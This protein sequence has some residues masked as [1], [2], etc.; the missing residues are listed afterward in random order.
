MAEIIEDDGD[1]PGPPLEARIMPQL[2]PR[3]LRG[4]DPAHELH[5]FG[6][7]L[8]AGVNLTAIPGDEVRQA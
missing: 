8:D 6:L 3:G 1:A 7:A 2:K 5:P 4:V